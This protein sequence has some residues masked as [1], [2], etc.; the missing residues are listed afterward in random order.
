MA[1]TV[2]GKSMVTPLLFLN[3]VM[4][5]IVLGFA[6][7]CLNHFINGQS[8]YPGV[9]GN[10]ATF[11]FLVFAILAGVI[12]VVSKLASAS[13]I[14]VWRNDSLAAASSSSLIAWAITALAFGLACKEIHLGG[15]RGWR[16]RVLEAFIIILALTQLIYV[17]LLHAGMFSGKY[18]PG[19]TDPDYGHEQV[20]KGSTGVA[21]RA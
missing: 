2:V 16:L 13:H 18:G 10:G 17:V 14:R 15:Y 1:R 11:Y 4:Y 19:Y 7:W 12:G 20:P 6:S 21:T 5:I 9:A 3:L 8:H